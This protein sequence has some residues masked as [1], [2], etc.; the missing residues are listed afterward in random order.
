ML[1]SSRAMHIHHACSPGS[2]CLAFAIPRWPR[3]GLR[4]PRRKPPLLGPRKAKLYPRD[5]KSPAN[6]R[7]RRLYGQLEPR[8]PMGHQRR[9]WWC[10]QSVLEMKQQ[11]TLNWL[12]LSYTPIWWIKQRSWFLFGCTKWMSWLGWFLSI[13]TGS[14]FFASSLRFF[15]LLSY[16]WF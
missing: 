8:R 14:A 4:R 6:A 3:T 13:W 1:T 9:R 15:F 11:A 5:H 16:L 2:H 10:S 12:L 7:R